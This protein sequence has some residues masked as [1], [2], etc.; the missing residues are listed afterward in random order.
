MKHLITSLLISLSFFSVTISHAADVRPS[1]QQEW[2][3]TLAAAKKE[4]RFNFYVGR[5]GTESF[6][7]EFRK[8]YPE[9]KVITV[10]GTA[11]LTQIII[12]SIKGRPSIPSR[13]R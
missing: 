10:N 13:M 6:L 11:A 2:E 8:E 7:N 1:W 12:S 3:K 5:Y 4:G 9:I